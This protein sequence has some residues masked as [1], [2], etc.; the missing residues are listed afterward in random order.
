MENRVNLPEISGRL[1]Q[2]RQTLQLTPKEVSKQTGISTGNLSELENGKYP[3]SS[4]TLILLSDLYGV[5]IDWILKGRISS[6]QD[7]LV[8]VEALMTLVDREVKGF[9]QKIAR[10]W[11]EGDRDL[12][13]WIV[14]QLRLAFPR[15]AAEIKNE[16]EEAAASDIV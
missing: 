1:K 3:P 5:S 12:R 13:G 10:L 11:L 16:S 15:I 4:K 2:I 14:V 7:S 8:E 6:Y 9:F